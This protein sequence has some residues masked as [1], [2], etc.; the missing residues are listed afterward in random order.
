MEL[1]KLINDECKKLARPKRIE[2]QP[3]LFGRFENGCA[4]ISFSP[5]FKRDAFKMTLDELEGFA[6]KERNKRKTEKDIILEIAFSL[7]QKFS[8][9][10]SVLLGDLIRKESDQIP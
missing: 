2:K 10:G 8:A 3:D 6:R 7:K 1:T 5:G 4:I 9:D